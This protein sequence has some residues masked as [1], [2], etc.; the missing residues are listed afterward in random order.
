MQ[1]NRTRKNAVL[2][3]LS[4]DELRILDAKT[5]LTGMRSRSATLRQLIVEAMLYEVDYKE[6]QNTNMQLAKI[7]NNINQIAKRI[8]ETR[9][10]Y[11]ADIDEV[12]KE[13]DK[14]W[15]LQKSTLSRQPLR[16]Q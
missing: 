12:K 10:I 15:Q 5:K 4:D 14:V 7:G 1:N 9:S 13:I 6:L 8:N 3:Y 2:L 11:Q 16:E